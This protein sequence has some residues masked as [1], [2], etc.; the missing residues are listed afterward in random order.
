MYTHLRPRHQRPIATRMDSHIITPQPGAARLSMLADL[1]DDTE[2]PKWRS[3]RESGDRNGSYQTIPT[4]DMEA[5]RRKT[6]PG[7]KEHSS[8]PSGTHLVVSGDEY[9]DT[10]DSEVAEDMAHI[11][12][13]ASPNSD[14]GRECLSRF[15]EIYKKHVAHIDQ[16]ASATTPQV[17]QLR[18]KI[19]YLSDTFYKTQSAQQALH[20]TIQ[21]YGQECIKV[22][23]SISNMV[24]NFD[25]DC[26]ALLDGLAEDHDLLQQRKEGLR[27]RLETYAQTKC[28]LILRGRSPEGPHVRYK[29]ARAGHRSSLG[30]TLV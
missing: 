30:C 25:D 29:I 4:K 22:G 23:Q 21:L 13:H 8:P 17:A 24:E 3:K 1:D 6:P 5:R 7:H 9:S 27:E 2:L 10:S 15:E 26:D 11:E 14:R 20:H 19:L 18:A 28:A 12:L 16:H